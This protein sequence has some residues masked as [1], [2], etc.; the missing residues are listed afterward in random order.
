M[1]APSI[2][3]LRLATAALL[4]CSPSLAQ[5]FSHDIRPLLV[6]NCAACHNPANPDPRGPANFLKATE[7]KDIQ[8]DRG[9]WRSVAAQLRNRTM[10]PGD[11]KLTED[12]RLQI[13]QWLEKELVRT[14]CSVDAYAGAAAVRRLNRREYHNTV[15]DLLGVSLDVADIL[16]ADGTG[17]A[18][19]DTNGETLYI[20][21]LLLEGYLEAAQR[22][23]DDVIVTPPIAKVYSAGEMIPA[24]DGETRTL[25]AKEEITAV[26]SVYVEGQYD[27]RVLLGE[28]ESASS[29]ALKVDG[30][31]ADPLGVPRRGGGY[32]PAEG[33]AQARP[34]RGGNAFGTIV[35]LGRGTHTLA[36]LAGAGPA[37]VVSLQVAGGSDEA[38]PLKRAAHFRLLGLEP[39]MTPLQPRKAAEQLLTNFLP[40]AFRRPVAPAELAP[41]LA[42]YDR[43]AG[44]S[45]PYEERVKLALK[46]VLASPGFLFQM[47]QRKTEPGIY[48]L[49]DHELAS[50]LSYFLWSTMPDERLFRLADQGRL[51]DPAVL[52]A[53]ADRMLDDPRSRAFV[54]TFIGQWLGTR[55][56]GGRVMPLITEI[57]SYYDAEIAADLR[58]QPILLFDR[59]V[60]ENRSVLDLLDGDYIYLTQRLVKFYQVEDE[61][62]GVNDNQFHLVELPNQRRAGLLGL[63]GILGMGSHYEQTSPIL[64]GAW[65]LDALLGTPVPPPPPNVPV[66]DPGDKVSANMTTRQIVL[67][68]RENPAC[69]A[70]HKLMDPIGF[71]LENF[72]WMGRWRNEEKDGQP[73]DASGELPS[74]ETF[75]GPVELRQTLLAKKGDFTRQ[76]VGKVLGYALGR[77]LQDGDSCTIQQI[78]DRLEADDYR[79][80]TL[81]REV[82]SSVPFRNTQ[83]GLEKVTTIE[84]PRLSLSAITALTQDA[85]SHNNQVKDPPK[86]LEIDPRVP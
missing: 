68:H 15:R 21:P 29:V 57:Q 65:V 30:V 2:T 27:V 38:S 12:N 41:F 71:G 64:R 59:I 25:N 20:P 37:E 42:L 9:L 43:A 61:V 19:F 6:E 39:G 85:K 52:T 70:C 56:I 77:S 72:D 14:A 63:A 10:P 51:Q 32:G 1:R 33:A 22:I 60:R 36:L 75:D 69:A 76:L 62:E 44:R 78:V 74:G 50:R 67:Q 4:V 49:S 8:E 48:P 16:P 26:V 46:G 24:A 53:E 81:V 40:K 66:L 17:G 86:R 3:G 11:S 34:R 5:D 35:R 45:D 28:N 31:E 7:A 79:A 58:E 54:D 13:S 84:G 80:R 82:V 47:E 73:I 55:D 23:L 18:G 83:G